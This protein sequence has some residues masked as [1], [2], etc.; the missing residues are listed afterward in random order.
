MIYIGQKIG[1]IIHPPTKCGLRRMLEPGDNWFLAI[2]YTER[3]G[4]LILYIIVPPIS[5]IVNYTLERNVTNVV[6]FNKLLDSCLELAC[7][8][9]ARQLSHRLGGLAAM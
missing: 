9:G 6:R 5:I 7:L 8:S 4:G 2:S 3:I 1:R